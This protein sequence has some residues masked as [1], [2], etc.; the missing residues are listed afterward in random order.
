MYVIG[1]PNTNLISPSEKLKVKIH[2]VD[3]IPTSWQSWVTKEI[4][5]Y[6]QIFESMDNSN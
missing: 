4:D 6:R 5:K 1:N 3:M 2:S